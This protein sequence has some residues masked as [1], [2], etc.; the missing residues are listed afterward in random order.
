M[1]SFFSEV[2]TLVR[3]E[4][5][6]EWRQKY[7]INGIILYVVSTVFVCYLSFNLRIPD[8]ITWN[9]LFWI[10]LLFG[11]LNAVSKS[12]QQERDGRHFFYYQLVSPEA[13]IVSKI[14]YNSL[15][16]LFISFAGLFVF[17]LVLGNPVQDHFLFIVNLFLGALGFSS[18]FTMI[19]GIASKSTNSSTLMSV[20][21]L[22]VIIPMLLM[23]I[24]VS[25][26]A[27]DGLQRNVSYDEIITIFAINTIIL[28]VS[29]ILFPYL[30]RS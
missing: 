18:T 26:N 12:F 19:S 21:G 10:I 11:A 28:T 30:W 22:P 24:K 29:I 4:F 9:A 2:T 5:V 7:A 6:L 3:K 1:S 15:L 25:K 20:L 16:M 23:L 17:S 14:I 13:I 27:M 8:G